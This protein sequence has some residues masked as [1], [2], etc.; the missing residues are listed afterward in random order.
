MCSQNALFLLKTEE[1]PVS[2]GKV[3]K[4]LQKSKNL[5]RKFFASP[6]FW[7]AIKTFAKVRVSNHRFPAFQNSSQTFSEIMQHLGQVAVLKVTIQVTIR[8]KR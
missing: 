3:R 1:E 6:S 7:Q 4:M 8:T 2:L 5:N